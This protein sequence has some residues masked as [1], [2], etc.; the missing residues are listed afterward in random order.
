MMKF[1][2][3]KEETFTAGEQGARKFCIAEGLCQA[4][5]M[6]MKVKNNSDHLQGLMLEFWRK[7]EGSQSDWGD[8]S[9]TFG[10]IPQVETVLCFPIEHLDSQT[11]YLPRTPA[12]LKTV[13]IGQKI[14]PEEVERISVGFA[15][16]YKSQ[17]IDF[18]EFSYS[19]TLPEFPVPDMKIVDSLGQ[20]KLQD[21]QGKTQSLEDLQGYLQGELKKT[22]AFPDSWSQY[23]GN[24]SQSYEKTGFFH[25]HFDQS[26][27]QWF[28]VDPD[29]YGFF[30]NGL[31]C[32]GVH[33][34]CKITDIEKLFDDLDTS[35]L[36]QK[37]QRIIPETE[38]HSGTYY[39]FATANMIRVFGEDYWEKWASI[40]K[41]RL[42]HWGY[43]TIGNWSDPQFCQR[44]KLP[45]VH[46]LRDFPT[47]ELQIYRDFPDVFAT[48]FA[49]NTKTFAKQLE[50]FRDDPYLIG[51]FLRNEP[52]WAFVE[53]ISLAEE[54][55]ETPFPSAT[56]TACIS[57]LEE[58][59]GDISKLNEAWHSSFSS[60]SDFQ[61]V[62]KKARDYSPE[63]L[64]DMDE[65][66]GRMIQ[67]YNELPSLACKEVDPNHM[68]LG[69][70][71]AY[72][73]HKA[74]LCGCEHF[75]VFSFNCYQM[76]PTDYIIDIGEKTKLPVMIGEYHFGAVDRGMMSSGLKAVANQ[77][78]RGVAYRQYLE[79]AAAQKYCVGAHYFTLY[80]QGYLGRFDGE[81]FQIGV[82]DCCS[83]PYEDFIPE[84]M[85]CNRNIYEVKTG[86]RPPTETKAIEIPRIGF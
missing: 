62:V 29:G 82:A 75:D 17:S 7:E 78:E 58:K 12:K 2:Q 61:Q 51:Y 41:E 19:N 1:D 35:G 69:M 34:D 55:L 84:M 46:P 23:G 26:L 45:Y 57:Y 28:L 32:V 59:Y 70:R 38:P 74:L 47:T 16:N 25:T 76:D 85:D 79:K 24:L 49:E 65:F 56:K 50:V 77:A 80:D 42:L 40:T 4:K 71:Y 31:D 86:K 10:L 11:M 53:G 83:R 36:L 39:D 67:L 27:E 68:N 20:C 48:E 64:E 54:L 8:L 63:A 72:I 5:Y 22:G 66:S 33:A 81:N 14:L 3:I 37:A 44:A 6:V 18:L 52:L 30:S 15:P 43:N 21:W 73:W 13:V 60:F 9:V